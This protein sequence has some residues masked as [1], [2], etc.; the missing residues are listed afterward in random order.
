MTE[1]AA[2]IAV[3]AAFVFVAITKS[4]L[5]QLPDSQGNG[6]GG[7]IG[8]L[9]L[10]ATAA[11]VLFLITWRRPVLRILHRIRPRQTIWPPSF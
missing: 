11:V 4:V 7:V 8:Y 3:V 5:H 6:D 10:I 2:T 9:L 1:L